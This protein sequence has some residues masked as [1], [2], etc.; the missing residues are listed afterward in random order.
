[1]HFLIAP[2]LPGSPKF[3]PKKKRIRQ[4]WMNLQSLPGHLPDPLVDEIRAVA[5]DDG[6]YSAL[7]SAI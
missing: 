3:S 5:V 1:M 6:D 7:I 4:S 2:S